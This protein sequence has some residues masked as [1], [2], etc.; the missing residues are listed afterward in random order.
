MRKQIHLTRPNKNKFI[1]R[2]WK[3]RTRAGFAKQKIN[4]SWSHVKMVVTR[5]HKARFR[6]RNIVHNGIFQPLR[7]RNVPNRTK[8]KYKWVSTH[9]GSSV[10]PK[11][12]Y[13][14]IN[15][16]ETL[17]ESWEPYTNE[18]LQEVGYM[19]SI[20]VQLYQNGRYP[21]PQAPFRFPRWYIS[22]LTVQER[23]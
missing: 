21:G 6:G 14:W 13:F 7:S 19:C 2:G 4:L 1:I 17:P 11:I 10:W 22:T 16:P 20:F 5:Y 12:G 18:F 15:S 3:L 9:F 8:I 23:F